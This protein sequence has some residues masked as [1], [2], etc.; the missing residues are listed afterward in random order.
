MDTLDKLEELLESYDGTL[1]L[2]SHDR[3]FVDRLA[4]STIAMNGRGDIV[5]TPGGWTDFI[6]QN[7]GFLKP[8]IHQ[9]PQDAEAARR[10]AASPA[11]ATLAAPA[12]KPAKMSFKD[13]HRLKELEG[14]L[15]SLPADIARHEAT[16]NDPGLYARDRKAFDRATANADRARTLLAAAEEEWLALEAM[17]ESLQSA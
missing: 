15:A 4:T 8:G 13:T 2:V 12:K 3:D 17:R 10:A 11:P 9:R 6:R 5:E 14:L 7:P 16:L 1:I